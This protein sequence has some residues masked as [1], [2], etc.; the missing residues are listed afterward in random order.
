MDE[1]EDKMARNELE[2]ACWRIGLLNK[3]IAKMK[4][5]ISL[6]TRIRSLYEAIVD[7]TSTVEQELKNIQM[8]KKVKTNKLKKIQVL[9]ELKKNTKKI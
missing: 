2:K 3:K 4:L 5:N 7:L 1:E 6:R 9:V 8:L